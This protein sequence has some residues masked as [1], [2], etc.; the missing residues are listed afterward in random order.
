MSRLDALAERAS[1]GAV[2]ET[3]RTAPGL[4]RIER[5]FTRFLDDPDA[6][7]ALKKSFHIALENRMRVIALRADPPERNGLAPI[8]VPAPKH[9]LDGM[10]HRVLETAAGTLPAAPRASM[11]ARAR[12]LLGVMTQGK[13]V[14]SYCPVIH[15]TPHQRMLK[16][17]RL[18]HDDPAGLASALGDWLRDPGSLRVPYGWFRENFDPFG[19][20]QALTRIVDL[21]WGDGLESPVNEAQPSTD[22]K[23]A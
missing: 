9:P 21:L 1:L 6:A 14:F 4:N 10:A 23:T 7:L 19:D 20:D 5:A 3:F 16:E 22:R 13:P 18:A 12:H 11:W 8:A 15:D 2:E 17:A